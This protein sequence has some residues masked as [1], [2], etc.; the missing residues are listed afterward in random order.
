MKP[1][2]K[3]KATLFTI[4]KISMI[5]ATITSSQSVSTRLKAIRTLV[6]VTVFVAGVVANTDADGSVTHL[7]VVSSPQIDG[8]LLATAAI[9]ANDIWAVGF[10]DQVP[11]PPV[12]DSTLAEHFNGTSWSIVPTPTVS[13]TGSEF[14]GVAGAAS[15]DVWAVGFRFGTQNPDFGLQLI[16]HWDGTSWSVDTTGPEIEGDLLRGVTVV[17]SN[18]VWAV[19]S[20]SGNA[21]VEHWDGTRW[22]IVSNPVIAS[23]GALSAVS[24]DS[25]NDVWAVGTAGNG[26]PPILHFDG[27]NWSLSLPPSHP[28]IEAASVTALSP[29]NVWAVGTVGVFFNHRTHRKAAIEHWD[30]TSWSLLSS[31]DPTNSPG[32][33]SFLNGIVPVSANSIWAVGTVNT[34]GGGQATL[35]EHWDGTSWRIINSPNPGNFSNGLFGA[36]ALSD[37]T[38][39]AVGFQQDQGFDKI[40][41]ILHN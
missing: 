7:R 3:S 23:A 38:V 5:A 32:L 18:N 21:L 2:S 25:A 19:G 28:S 40:P 17:S 20:A 4:S 39:A 29:T 13:S 12:V 31:P 8:E 9:A 22:S 26:G 37:G 36:T 24:A 34:S 11:A 10:S 16:E 41:L 6:L 14:F 1:T 35:T 33:D 15:N 30:G 27:T